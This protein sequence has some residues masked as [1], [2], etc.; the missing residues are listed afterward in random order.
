MRPT[1]KAVFFFS[2][3][4]PLALLIVSAWSEAWY[5]SL[6]LPG[7][8]VAFIAADAVSILPNRRLLAVPHVPRYLYVGQPGVVD[9][10][11]FDGD[12]C[13]HHAG[14]AKVVRAVVV[15]GDDRPARPCRPPNAAADN[16]V[17]VIK[18]L[19]EENVKS[20]RLLGGEKLSITYSYGV[21]VVKLPDVLPTEYTN[22]LEIEL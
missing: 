17:A 2:L 9:A 5:L 7:M 14:V 16:H 6:C 10:Q 3:S 11:V 21:L 1:P 20:V 18:G 15:R 4:V 22:C 19:E 13:R 12:M 8:A